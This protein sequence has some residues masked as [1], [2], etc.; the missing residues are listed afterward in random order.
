LIQGGT[1]AVLCDAERSIQ[2]ALAVARDA[3]EVPYIIP[4]GGAPEV[5]AAIRLREW[6]KMISGRE[7]L[8]VL[9]FA[10][11]LEYI[12]VILATNSGMHPIETLTE[13]RA[14]HNRGEKSME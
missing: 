3:I 2:N 10:N 9:G 11:A 13:L 5:E 12:A 6:A 1:N 7:Q 8:A 14:R 4:G